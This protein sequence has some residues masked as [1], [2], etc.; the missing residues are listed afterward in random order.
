MPDLFKHT[1]APDLT[2]GE[3]VQAIAAQIIARSDATAAHAFD[4]AEVCLTEYLATEKIAF[5]DDAYAWGASDAR[6]LADD[7]LDCWESE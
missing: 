3:F 6:A 1:T 2:R 7:E 4:C 5:G